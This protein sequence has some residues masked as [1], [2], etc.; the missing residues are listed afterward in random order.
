MVFIKISLL[1][2]SFALAKTEL[3]EFSARQN[4][5]N[6]KYYFKDGDSNFYTK[7]KKTLAFSSN[8]KAF[9]IL[10]MDT[11]SEFEVTTTDNSNFLILAKTLHHKVLNPSANGHI[12]HYN[13][14][15][16]NLTRIGSGI[17]PKFHLK[18]RFLS[19]FNTEQSSL[20]IINTEFMKTK[21]LIKI[22]SK[23]KYY[24]PQVELF[25][26]E[27]VIFTDLNDH[28]I[29]G[30]LKLNTTTKKRSTIY[31]LDSPAST[32]EICKSKS[33]L[34]ILESSIEDNSYSYIYSLPYTEEDI[35]K[36]T[37]LLDSPN[38]PAHG[39]S[40]H[41]ENNLFLIKKIPGLSGLVEE[42]IRFN[43]KDKKSYI[44]SDLK[45]T[46]NYV[47]ISG[48]ILITFR[49]KVYYIRNKLGEFSINRELV[50]E[51][52]L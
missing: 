34:Y 5:H 29:P 45:F 43:I 18:G 12:Y 27:T 51:N 8:Y 37:F 6:I 7:G 36:R 32:I 25:D 10:V 41:D 13:L 21:R 23:N 14:K 11:A 16:K 4:I 15:S 17:A 49:D 42:L 47:T 24:T 46:R 52:D 1:L 28:M 35:S 50:E 44:H 20:V 30:I 3:L 19:Y 48:D 2:I 39:L 22:N 40:C 9:E 38:G 26:E 33:T 31:K